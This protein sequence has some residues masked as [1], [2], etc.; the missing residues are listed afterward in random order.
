MD[1]TE[2]SGGNSRELGQGLSDSLAVTRAV[3]TKGDQAPAMGLG[4]NPK[5]K[6]NFQGKL[7]F[8]LL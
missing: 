1:S 5:P 7:E 3:F 6:L 4:L 8:H 2:Q